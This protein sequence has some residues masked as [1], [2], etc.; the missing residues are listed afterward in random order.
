M[1][2]NI[3]E[4]TN[5]ASIN[6]FL[7][8]IIQRID[9]MRNQDLDI[10]GITSGYPLLDKVTYGWQPSD[11]IVI[12]GRPSVGKTAFAINLI[13]NTALNFTKPTAVGF[14]SL[15]MDCT[16]IMQRFLS[17]TSEI[18]F[19][20][21]SRGKLEDHE[22]KQLYKKGIEILSNAPIMIDDSALN[23]Q[24][25]KAKCRKLKED[26]NVGLIV[27]DYLQLMF[28][29]D[30]NNINREQDISLITR[31]L[32]ALAK[33]LR[34][35]IIA[36]S[37][38]SREVEKRREGNRMPQLSD[39]RDSGAIEQDADMVIFLYNPEY[40]DINQNEM[41]QSNHGETHIKIAKNRNGSLDTIKLK[42]LKHIQK[43]DE[44]NSSDSSFGNSFSPKFNDDEAK[45]YIQKG[46]KVYADEDDNTPF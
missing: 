22:M 31:E 40:Y 37:Q 29:L 11:L 38:L 26:S 20:K 7:E 24:E 2:I 30:Q 28:G 6:L 43:F 1:T 12:A 32:K 3:K 18:T 14:F 21:I 23:I 25:L 45:L 35:P 33:E 13:L 44:D 8:N 42:F 36:L 17:A 4:E 41:G 10:S 5:S 46:T 16:K 27:I 34:I 19:E 39:L 9:Y 15:E